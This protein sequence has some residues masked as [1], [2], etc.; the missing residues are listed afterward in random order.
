MTAY[1]M[2]ATQEFLEDF[3]AIYTG[4]FDVD[5]TVLELDPNTFQPTCAVRAPSI[6]KDFPE[7]CFVRLD[8]E[9][10]LEKG[11]VQI[12]WSKVDED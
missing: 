4:I 1:R 10:D 6:P 8:V 2:K 3:R 11:I 12:I 7:G 9:R 5:I